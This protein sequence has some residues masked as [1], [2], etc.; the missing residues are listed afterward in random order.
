MKDYE[1]ELKQDETP[2]SAD[3]KGK[4]EKT[5][6]VKLKCK[7]LVRHSGQLYKNGDVIEMTEPEMKRLANICEIEEVKS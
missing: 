6:K 4:T 1:D 5:V 2:K 7:Q 3:K